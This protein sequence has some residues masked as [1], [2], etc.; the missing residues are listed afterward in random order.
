MTA[1]DER[2]WWNLDAEAVYEALD[3]PPTGLDA[4]QAAERLARFGP[5]RVRAAHRARPLAILLHQFTSPLVYVLLAAMVVSLAI[6]R[7]EDAIVI[8][9]VLALNAVIGF[10][11][12][13]R[14]ENA[15][16][17]LMEMLPIRATVLRGGEQVE[18]DSAQV[19]PGDVV[20][21]ESGDL[22]PADLRLVEAVG[23]ECDEAMITGE[24]VPVAKTDARLARDGPV[25]IADQPN[26]AFGGSAVTS[27]RGRGVVVATGARSQIG[28]IAEQIQ[29][30]E[31][32]ETPLQRRMARLGAALGL[33]IVGLSVVV[34]AA[35]LLRGESL[36][37]MFLT[38]VAIAVAAI[39]EGLPVVM[40]VALAIGVRRMAKRNAIVRRLP[41]VETLGSCTVIVTDKTGT[42][43]ENRMTVR[44][45]DVAG[46]VLALTGSGLDLEGR[47]ERDGEAVSVVPGDAVHDVLLTG[48]LCNEALLRPGDGS[49]DAEAQGDPTE[50]ALLVAA[51]KAGID[52]DGQL[53]RHPLVD[54]VPFESARKFA[55]TLHRDAH[56]DEIVVFVKGAPERVAA[57]CDRE[58][59]ADGER[60]LDPEDVV[61]RTQALASRGLRVRSGRFGWWRDADRQLEVAVQ[62][63]QKVVGA[64]VERRRLGAV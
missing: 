6:A 31:R 63:S 43:T 29:E 5:N 26:M 60:P 25:P 41:A 9:V 34:F 1:A 53:A 32:A 56:A 15:I 22:V 28:A 46:T 21:V 64:L 61:R 40:T 52:R 50:V 54:R 36:S 58:R 17:A 14:A 3:A 20:L 13:F 12:E 2:S 42:L 18:L 51:A 16:A 11:Q 59:T 57:M 27:G 7:G 49:G 19:V 23:L 38:A 62:A 8:G 30:I 33:V 44:N 37:D 24:S 39:P 55:A 47:V 10:M 4:A 45:L 35:G 48:A